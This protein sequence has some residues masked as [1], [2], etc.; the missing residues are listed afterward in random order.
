MTACCCRLTQPAKSS[1]TKASGGGS[2]SIYAERAP[3][4]CGNT[5]NARFEK[6]RNQ[7]ADFQGIAIGRLP[8][9]R[10]FIRAIRPGPS[11]RTGRGAGWTAEADRTARAA[12]TDGSAGHSR[13]GLARRVG[14]L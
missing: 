13:P 6:A 3:K 5:R 4:G 11:F 14:D 2:E 1:T 8:R 9:M 7:L 12:R 10:R